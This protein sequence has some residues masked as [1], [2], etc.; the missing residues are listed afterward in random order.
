MTR[1]GIRASTWHE[2]VAHWR[3]SGLSADAYARE[4]DI[5]LE[6]LKYWAR[7]VERGVV[8]PQMLAVCVSAAAVSGPLE[9]RRPSATAKLNGLDP[10]RRLRDTLEQ[11]PTCRNSKIDSLLSFADSTPA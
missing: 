11:L 2:R 8:R 9:L 1:Q 5:G 3:S 10:A 6:R 7:R 4:H